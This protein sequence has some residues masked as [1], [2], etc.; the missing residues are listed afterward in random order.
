MY[1]HSWFVVAVGAVAGIAAAVVVDGVA[2]WLLLSFIAAGTAVVIVLFAEYAATARQA[3][4][5]LARER[6]L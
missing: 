1:R 2:K 5:A 3:S 4:G 6:H